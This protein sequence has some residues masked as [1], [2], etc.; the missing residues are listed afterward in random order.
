[1]RIAWLHT[2]TIYSSWSMLAMGKVMRQLGHEVIEFAAPCDYW[3][4]P[5]TEFRPIEYK[6]LMA[7]LPKASNYDM[8][9]VVGPE[10]IPHWLNLMDWHKCPI[11][12]A[13][14]LESSK[15]AVGNY[16]EMAP[17]F[18][19]CFYPDTEDAKARGGFYIQPWVDTD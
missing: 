14:F 3:G 8:V 4:R 2:D 19:H 16:G 11:R 17:H 13:I 9:L 7:S 5:R 12:V 6:R 10:Y 1:M 18:T 15:R